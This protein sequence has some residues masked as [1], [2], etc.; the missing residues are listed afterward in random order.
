[1]ESLLTLLLL[2]FALIAGV[3]VLLALGVFAVAVILKRQ[4]RLGLARRRAAPTVMAAAHAMENRN[5]RLNRHRQ[6]RRAGL[7]GTALRTAARLLDDDR[8]DPQGPQDP[9]GRDNIR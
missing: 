9:W 8:R 4:G 1:M 2:R 5:D 3:L 7:A 6:D